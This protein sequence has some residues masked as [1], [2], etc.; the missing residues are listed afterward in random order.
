MRGQS[1]HQTFLQVHQN[2]AAHGSIKTKV[3]DTGLPRI[4]RTPIFEESVLHAPDRNLGS[5]VRTLPI[6]SPTSVHR[7]LQGEALHQFHVERVQLLQPEDH[8]RHIMPSQ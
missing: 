2:L 4:R 5:S 6:A 3:E 8:S 7:A 1:N